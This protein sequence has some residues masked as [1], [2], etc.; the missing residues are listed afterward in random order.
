MRY[1]Y[2]ISND[3]ENNVLHESTATKI[4]IYTKIRVL[5]KRTF[6]SNFVVFKLKTL[7]LHIYTTRMRIHKFSDFVLFQEIKKD[8]F[9]MFFLYWKTNFIYQNWQ[10]CSLWLLNRF[11]QLHWSRKANIIRFQPCTIKNINEHKPITIYACKSWDAGS[12]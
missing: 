9:T 1:F 6:C 12:C 8:S 4:L 3:K 2:W 5:S 11:L 10:S 7:F